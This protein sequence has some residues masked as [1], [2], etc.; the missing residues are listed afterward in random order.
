LG[1]RGSFG[2][3]LSAAA[4]VAVIGLAIVNIVNL[5]RIGAAGLDPVGR[6]GGPDR[7]DAS[8]EP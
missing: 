7:S 5:E 1:A 3:L 8:R 4:A 6:R 2:E